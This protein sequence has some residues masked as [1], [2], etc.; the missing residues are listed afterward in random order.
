ML[1]MWPTWPRSYRLPTGKQAKGGGIGQPPPPSKLSPHTETV[2]L[3]TVKKSASI[4]MGK[5]GEV[6][7]EMML[8][9]GSARCLVSQDIVLGMKATSK[10]A[11]RVC[12]KLVTAS[13]QPLSVV[14]HIAATVQIGQL[15]VRHN[16]IVVNSLVT[17]VI[18]GTDF[19]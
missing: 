18:L 8:D 19:L 5:I 6:P 7:T 10:A 4:I 3:V 14:D 13:G 1:D 12:P 9:S 15:K 17:P 2:V 16:F 11:L